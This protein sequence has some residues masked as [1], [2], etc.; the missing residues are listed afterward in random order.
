[1]KPRVIFKLYF[2]EGDR[3]AKAVEVMDVDLVHWE[4]LR[5]TLAEKYA[6]TGIL[7]YLQRELPIHLTRDEFLDTEGEMR[8]VDPKT[9]DMNAYKALFSL[10]VFIRQLDELSTS[11]ILFE[12]G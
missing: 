12:L 6:S 2:P 3:P 7:T 11:D 10:D 4:S 1:M 8:K 9:L 5:K